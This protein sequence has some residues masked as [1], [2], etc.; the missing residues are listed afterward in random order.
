MATAITTTDLPTP[1]ELVFCHYNIPVGDWVLSHYKSPRCAGRVRYYADSVVLDDCRFVVQ[2]GQR[3][4]AVR[5]QRRQVH[6]W[7][8]GRLVS[9]NET[10]PVTEHMRITYNPFRCGWF[11]PV[12][13]DNCVMHWVDRAYFDPH[14]HVWIAGDSAADFTMN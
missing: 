10:Q 8:T 6:A 2:E 14:R 11:H 1:G 3:Q 9:A 7:V 5:E 4:R 13:A 12:G